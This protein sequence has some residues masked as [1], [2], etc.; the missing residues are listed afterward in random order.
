MYSKYLNKNNIPCSEKLK[1]LKIEYEWCYTKSEY[2]YCLL[3]NIDTLP[4]C[5]YCKDKRKFYTFTFGY[6]PT[7]TN[8]ECRN[9]YRKSVSTYKTKKTKLERYG[10]PYFNNMEKNKQTCLEKYGKEY[11]RSTKQSMENIKKTKLERYGDP[12]YNN[13]EKN[14]QTCLEIYGVDNPRKHCETIDKI[15]SKRRETQE[16]N[17]TMIPLDQIGKWETYKRKVGKLTNQNDLSILE[18]YEKR[19][20]CGVE[21]GYQLDHI[22]PI[23]YGFVNNIQEELIS[24]IDNLVFIPWEE[25]RKKSNNLTITSM[26]LLEKWNMK[27]G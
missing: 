20:L 23:Y 5:P 14:K 19:S 13:M 26:K 22:V 24:S 27:S 6:R 4:S 21:N 17:G 16:E 3:N 15:Q 2:L 8:K 10:D 1:H 12:N 25:N 7:C 9:T 18:N 11:Y